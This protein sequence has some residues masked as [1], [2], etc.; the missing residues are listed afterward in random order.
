MET[1]TI[2]PYYFEDPFLFDETALRN[3]AANNNTRKLE[4][5]LDDLKLDINAQN[6]FSG[7]T[8]LHIA[9]QNK[10]PQA[11]GVLLREGASTKV[12]NR[13]QHTPLLMIL[14][15]SIENKEVTSDQTEIIYLLKQYDDQQSIGQSPAQPRT[16]KKNKQLKIVHSMALKT[17]LS[18][19]QQTNSLTTT[20]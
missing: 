9:T 11:V 17:R 6:P 16:N 8:A 18:S 12:K 5:L 19:L 13:K 15:T 20:Q 3:A 2:D 10:H 4:I 1:H 14:E 7:N